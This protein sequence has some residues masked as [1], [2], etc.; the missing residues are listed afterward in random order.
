MS[1]QH[2]VPIKTYIIVFAALIFLTLTTVGI[3]TV[4]LGPLNTIAALMIAAIK[5]TF[6][7]LFFMHLRYSKPLVGVVVFGSILWLAIL[8]GLILSD[9]ISRSWK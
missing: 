4:D 9:F 5:A 1:S 7:I 8:I 6:V 3:A 2:I